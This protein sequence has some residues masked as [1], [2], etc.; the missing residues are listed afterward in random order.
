MTTE[1]LIDNLKQQK[2]YKKMVEIYSENC[3]DENIKD[4]SLEK[5]I[6]RLSKPTK[7]CLSLTQRASR[8]IKIIK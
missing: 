7:D 8:R 5:F 2:N 6:K 1:T 4:D 3:L